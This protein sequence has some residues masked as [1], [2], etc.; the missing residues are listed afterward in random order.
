MRVLILTQHYAPEVTAGRFRL[1]SFAEELRR[2]GHA[3]T[4]I[5][6]VPNHPAGVI[7]EGYRA[8]PWVRRRHGGVDTIHTWVRTSP[9]KSFRSRIL[10]YG[11]FAAAAAA[12][13]GLQRNVD[14]VLAS[15]PPLTVG[16]P[17][18]VLARRH[19]CP[20]VFDVRDLWPESAVVL[21]ELSDPRAIRR[22]ER[23]ERWIY[24]QAQL[25]VAAND[26]FA[27][28][29][30][31]R[32]PER[33]PVRTISNGTT[34]D[35]LEIG[36]REPRPDALRR[37]PGEI[38]VTYAGN[39]GLA[40][41]LETAIAI[42]PRLDDRFRLLIVGDGPR[43]DALRAQAEAGGSQRIEFRDVVPRDRLAELLRAS[44]ALLVA[45]RQERTI[46]AKLYDYSA[47]GRPI[48]AMARGEMA[49]LIRDR[50]IGT[51]IDPDDE[52]GLL[53]AV[54]E[55]GAT[56]GPV[57]ATVAAAREFAAHHLRRRQAEILVGSIEALVGG[58]GGRAGQPG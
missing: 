48:L 54:R 55:L 22:A 4:V 40:Q 18:A 30:R 8:R 31:E 3:A 5:C 35:W 36:S 11:S 47:L 51:V 13:G 26:A 23:L 43:K 12:A 16:V 34:E 39:L 45:E 49:M 25:L 44:D 28:H 9:A 58:D 42:W 24:G 6:P 52:D 15:S 57:E 1:E 46:S 50:S 7:H 17:G 19:R 32:A 53:V 10:F 37:R 27:R 14:L 2:R 21:G 41:T 20:Y 29:V 56:D 38:V 33:T